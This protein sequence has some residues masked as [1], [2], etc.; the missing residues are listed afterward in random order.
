VTW[1][2]HALLG[3]NRKGAI[4]GLILTILLAVVFTALQG[5]EYVTAAFTMSDSTY[6][7]TFFLGTG[8]HGFH[9]IMGTSMLAV[10]GLRLISYHFTNTHHVGY[11]A[12]ILY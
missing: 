3:G 11:E 4:L 7:N 8:S 9:V 2:H 12:A 1:S 6:G 5:Y 10:A